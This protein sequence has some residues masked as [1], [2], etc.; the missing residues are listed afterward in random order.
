MS[1]VK[2]VGFSVTPLNKTDQYY[3]FSLEEDPMHIMPDGVIFHNS[4]KSVLEQSIV[5]HVSRYA[6]RFQLV[7]VN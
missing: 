3:G 6:D 4:G 7:G 5:G 1:V 2:Q